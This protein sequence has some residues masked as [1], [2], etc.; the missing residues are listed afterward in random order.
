MPYTSDW[1]QYHYPAFAE[2]RDRRGMQT[3][4]SDRDGPH[5]LV[6]LADAKFW[7]SIG[8]D[9]QDWHFDI[10]VEGRHN[11]HSIPRVLHQLGLWGDPY[12]RPDA[13]ELARVFEEHLPEVLDALQDDS[14]RAKLRSR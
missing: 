2:L 8:D 5:W 9:R 11:Y 12:I 4:R 7:L 1:L 3:I 13:S 14:F 10:D 6:V